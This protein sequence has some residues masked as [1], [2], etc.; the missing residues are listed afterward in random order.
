M[1]V[2]LERGLNAMFCGCGLLETNKWR[3]YRSCHYDWNDGYYYF[4]VIFTPTLIF[5]LSPKCISIFQKSKYVIELG[6][7][8]IP[9]KWLLL[10][11]AI[12]AMVKLESFDW[13]FRVLKV[14][15]LNKLKLLKCKTVVVGLS[16][17]HQKWI[18]ETRN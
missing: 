6:S 1:L 7:K 11:Q 3:G 12:M 10:I 13:N 9:S 15:L 8:S 16:F 2:G 5:C 17:S 4:S 14:C 18:Y